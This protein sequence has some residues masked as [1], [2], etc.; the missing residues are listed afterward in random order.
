MKIWEVSPKIWAKLETNKV[1][2]ESQQMG[3]GALELL[4]LLSSA[5]LLILA[6]H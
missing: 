1:P 4:E 6:R 5:V 3:A 2:W